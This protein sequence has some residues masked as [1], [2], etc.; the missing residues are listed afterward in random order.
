MPKQTSWVR[1]HITNQFTLP[2]AIK[3]LQLP[4]NSGY[5]SHFSFH[6]GACTDFAVRGFSTDEIQ[7]SGAGSLLHIN[8][9]FPNQSF[10]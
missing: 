4:N 8:L 3:H 6:I 10:N 7:K 1:K 9:T 2:K 5:K